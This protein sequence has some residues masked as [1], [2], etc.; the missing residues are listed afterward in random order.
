MTG[1]QVHGLVSHKCSLW[2]VQG[3]LK[4]LAELGLISTQPVGRAALHAVN[5]DHAA[6]GP[7]R[8]LLDPVAMLTEAVRS[9]VDDEVAAV[10]LFGSVAR[11]D[12]TADSDIDLAVIAPT[13]WH[14]Q[15]EVADRVRER[16]GNRCDVLTFSPAEFARLAARGEP[17]VAEILAEGVTVLGEVPRTRRGVT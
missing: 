11:G 10:I 2:T 7:L 12:A 17:V 1:R 15:A 8:A 4:N 13:R 16:L 6:I 3:E 14:R 9:V 5:E